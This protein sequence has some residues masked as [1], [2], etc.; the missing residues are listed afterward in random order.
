MSKLAEQLG[1]EFKVGVYAELPY[2][3]VKDSNTATP[4]LLAGFETLNAAI[5]YTYILSDNCGH[6]FHS[7]QIVKV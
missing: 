2:R 5:E 3:V 7:L 4:K 1:K 6:E